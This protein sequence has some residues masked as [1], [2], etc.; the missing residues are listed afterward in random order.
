MRPLA[1]FPAQLAWQYPV[2]LLLA[3]ASVLFITAY[4]LWRRY[5]S[6]RYLMQQISELNKLS[7]AG[8]AIV[9]AQLNLDELVALIAREAGTVI[10]N[11]T[12]QIGL[13]EDEL[14]HII[15]WTINGEPQKAQSFDLSENM[16]VVGWVRQERKPLLVHDFQRELEL[17][18]AR[19]RYISHSPPRSAIFIPLISGDQA[20]GIMAA[21]SS[22]P[23]RFNEEDMRRLMILA[24]QAAAAIANAFLYA[25]EQKRAAQLELVSQIAQKVN[26][27]QD[28]DEIFA[29]VVHLTREQF[30]FQLVSIMAVEPETG[31]AVLKASSSPEVKPGAMRVSPGEGLIGLALTTRQTVVSN[32]TTKDERYI[33]T[34]GNPTVDAILA[35]THAE[36]VI[37][38]VVE[39][40]LLGILDVQARDVNAF[41]Q[42]EQ[43]VLETLAAGVAM[44]I[45][46]VQQLS[47]QREQAWLT[48]AQLQVA[49]ALSHSENLEDAAATIARLTPMLLGVIQCLVLIWD[50]EMEHYVAAAHFGLPNEFQLAPFAIGQWPVLDAAHVGQQ[51]LTT[52]KTSPWP[53]PNGRTETTLFPLINKNQT[54]GH[55]IVNLPCPRNGNKHDQSALSP[56]QTELLR[57]IASQT[58]QAIANDQ[59]Q[60]AQQEEAWV[61]TALL[62]VAETVNS[63]IALDEILDTIMRFVP[64]LVGVKTCLILIWDER[65]EMF[66]CGPSYGISEMG[67]G[68]IEAQ[69]IEWGEFLA[70]YPQEEDILAPGAAYYSMRLPKWLCDIFGSP[71]AE[72]F[73]LQARSNMV[74]AMLIG[75]T[76]NGRSLTGR[77]LQIL[78]GIAHQAATA[79]MN[80]Q[81]YRESAERS[82]LEKEIDV[83]RRIQ[84]SLMPEAQPAIPL[85]DVASHW[86]AARQ[87]SG[88]F[89]DFIP[90][91]GGCWGIVIADVADK[92]FGAALFMALCRT[93]IRTVA[94][95]RTDPVETL[96][97]AN[98]IICNDAY[99]DLFVTVFYAIWD[100]QS[101]TLT[102]ANGGHNPPIL[103]RA[104]GRTS[105][106]KGSG[107]A[108]GVITPIEIDRLEI[109]L[110]PQDTII[111][112]TDGVTEAINEAYD[113]FGVERLKYVAAA[114]QAHSSQTVIQAITHAVSDHA[115]ETAQFDD[116]TLVVAKYLGKRRTKA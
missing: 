62:R 36:V 104:D 86:Q 29:Q 94:F 79:V 105:L 108:L 80:D 51:P 32:N 97:R 82:R 85:M 7:Q 5:R 111:F 12:F 16:G 99:S 21:Q 24:N 57:N 87:V 11:Q 102:Y 103:L 22:Q 93:I 90:L 42:Q 44:A 14:Y 40:E 72:T 8:R 91:A 4:V 46:R 74:G 115:G 63:L 109:K 48:T 76:A 54:I 77:R 114:N 23:N 96:L 30:N 59:L 39:S 83:A 2:F 106:L 67:R 98:E 56:R 110:R 31:A 66:H 58:A 68:I 92:G 15:Y 41:T 28:L 116:I 33:A 95:S 65:N 20:I 112:Y 37:P 100:S 113:E 53:S 89:Y 64:M 43:V 6:R 78:A 18:P 3:L 35:G 47:V 38:L 88:D 81:L 50:D 55:L 49:E 25:A 34:S 1:L 10:D 69:A 73:M 60:Q 101:Q 52:H 61:N 45:H 71:T 19:P 13:F 75:P 17:L 107:M 70:V 84:S 26:A 9:A 27:I